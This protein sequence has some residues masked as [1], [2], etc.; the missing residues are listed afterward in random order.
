MASG[1]EQGGRTGCHWWTF[2]LLKHLDAF[3]AVSFTKCQ[4][5]GEKYKRGCGQKLLELKFPSLFAL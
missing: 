2:K 4:D 3:G 5:H 1:D